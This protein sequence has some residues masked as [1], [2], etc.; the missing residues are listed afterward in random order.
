MVF[1]NIAFFGTGNFASIASFEISSVY[2]FITIF[3][4]REQKIPFLYSIVWYYTTYLIHLLLFAA[5]SDGSSPYFQTID[6]IHACHVSRSV[7]SVL[8]PALELSDIVSFPFSVAI[9]F[10]YLTWA[11]VTFL[12]SSCE[13]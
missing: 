6:T 3:S 7:M 12:S 13:L 4:V 1:F 9:L 11:K 5:I 2:R 10:L 8:F